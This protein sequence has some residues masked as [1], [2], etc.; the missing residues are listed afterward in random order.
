[1]AQEI[2]NYWKGKCF[3]CSTLNAHGLGLRFYL[4]QDGCYAKCVIPDRYCG[5]DG[6]VHG[7]MTALLL[8]E[9]CQWTM[10]GRTGRMGLT[11]ELS[12]RYLRPVPTNTE[13]IVE[14]TIG[15]QGEKSTVVHS[16]VR[17]LDKTVLAE[18]K[19]TWVMVEPAVIAKVSKIGESELKAFLANYPIAMAP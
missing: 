3:G 18:G 13:I 15:T 4:S 19:S 6:I 2:P 8:D 10:I 12:V 16:A 5:V 7:G 11:R 17:S 1:M 14:G 9:I